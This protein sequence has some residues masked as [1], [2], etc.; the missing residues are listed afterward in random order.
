MANSP[1][2]REVVDV[3]S[4][5]ADT[6]VIEALL[7]EGGM[8]AVYLASHRRLPGK[9]VAIKMLHAEVSNEEIFARF[10][11]EAEIA[12]RL[13][14]P[15]I[16]TVHDFNVTPGG[17]PYLILEYL[18]GESL[19]ERIAAGP[20]P[21]DQVM[22]IARQIGSGLAAAHRE[23][24][25][26]RDL[27][28]GNIF[29]VP[30]EI[31][32]RVVEIAKILDFG[33][34]KIRGSTTVKTQESTLLG[35]PQYMAPEQAKGDHQTVDE[36]TDIF[37][38]GAIVYEMLSGHA[39]FSGNN[40][41]EVVFKVVY[42]QPAP[43]V[44]LVPEAPA[45]VVAAV[46]QAMAKPVGDRFR[47]VNGFVEALT[48]QPVSVYQP[49]PIAAT[50]GGA[51]RSRASG[52]EAFENTMHSLGDARPPLLPHERSGGTVSLRS[53]TLPS[54]AGSGRTPKLDPADLAPA[55]TVAAGSHAGGPSPHAATAI[56][57]GAPPPNAVTRVGRR[58]NLPPFGDSS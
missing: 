36:R 21:L 18:H 14:H 44:A 24:I 10:R 16:V 55:R 9:R 2:R 12:S 30:T 57:G 19:G 6:Y 46:N 25:V 7:G 4:V 56:A 48:G 8:G 23:G 17:I 15:N 37:A 45:R 38:L 33:I 28:P 35:T 27:K 1:P 52:G 20:M 53:P 34:S 40:I 51:A 39:A 58:S 22:S 50:S 31:D 43:L 49:P 32:G 26:H 42:E 29:I 3:G 41:P 54:E 13:G 5:I 47:S 11:R